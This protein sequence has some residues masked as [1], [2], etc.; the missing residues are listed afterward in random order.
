MKIQRIAAFVMD[1]RGG[2]PAGVVLATHLPPEADMLRIARDVGYSETAFA[3]Q[4]SNIWDTRYFSPESEVPFCGHA[5][6]ALGAALAMEYGNGTYKLALKHSQIAI[7]AKTE[8]K[9]GYGVLRSPPT[10]SEAVP[11]DTLLEAMQLF[12]Y[13]Y[14]DLDPDLPAMLAN[15]GSNH[16]IVPLRTR[17]LL[18]RM[19]YDLDLGRAFM[20]RHDLVT[21]AFIWRESSRI[22]HARNAFASG[23]VLE[24]PAT[25]AA[26]A[27]LAGM[28]RDQQLLS[29][30]DLT[31]YQGEDMGRPSRIDVSFS[32]PVGSAVSVGGASAVILEG[33]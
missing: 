32:G 17:S 19:A 28:L 10:S 23:G 24:D 14:D 22:F 9:Q 2:N 31:I 11:K 8:G 16:L 33:A 4:N 18:A 21:V 27:A 13:G 6:I 7:E 30:G 26:A 3:A 15:G 1:G 29:S 12:G 25:G 5:T 20:H